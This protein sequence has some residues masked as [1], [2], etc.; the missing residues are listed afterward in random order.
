[1][2]SLYFEKRLSKLEKNKGPVV[3]ITDKEDL[4]LNQKSGETRRGRCS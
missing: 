1:V 4:K 2:G 3:F